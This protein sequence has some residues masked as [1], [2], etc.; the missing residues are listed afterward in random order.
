MRKPVALSALILS[1]VF[2]LV[3]QSASAF[4]ELPCSDC[5]S[6]VVTGP[7]PHLVT[8]Q[9]GGNV[10]L[11]IKGI[12]DVPNNRTQRIVFE[13]FPGPNLSN[14]PNPTGH[15]AVLGRG[16]MTING[17]YYHY[18]GTGI[19]IGDF[20]TCDGIGIENF[21]LADGSNG[22]SKIVKCKNVQFQNALYRITIDISRFDVQWNLEKLSFEYEGGEPVEVWVPVAS[23]RCRGGVPLPGTDFSMCSEISTAVGESVNY[24]NY[25]EVAVADVGLRGWAV[26][27]LRISQW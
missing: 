20:G 24:R 18:V 15:M 13:F 19:A 16:Q 9:P 22:W 25:S 17:I 7:G 2:A 5:Q 23:D 11:S 1:L 3:G 10:V 26:Y 12:P 27:D 4:E 14:Q 6:S 21:H 8:A